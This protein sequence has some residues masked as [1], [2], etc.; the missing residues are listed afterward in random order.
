MKQL[1]RIKAYTRAIE[2]TPQDAYVWSTLQKIKSQVESALDAV[3]DMIVNDLSLV[4]ENRKLAKIVKQLKEQDVSIEHCECPRQEVGKDDGLV[5][6]IAGPYTAKDNSSEARHVGEAIKIGNQILDAGH[7]PLVPH[8][9]FHLEI[10]EA[11]PYEEWLNATK[12]LLRKCD[13]VFRMTGASSGSDEEVKLA[14][15]LGIPVVYDEWFKTMEDL[16]RELDL[17]QQGL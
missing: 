11:R 17:I 9:F 4:E 15:S 6:F 3:E 2:K 10:A 7:T 14:E 1:L 12:N 8:L 13:C 16:E 5:V